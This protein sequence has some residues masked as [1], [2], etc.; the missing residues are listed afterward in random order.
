[1]LT[2]EVYRQTA[3]QKRHDTAQENPSAKG[4]ALRGK[5][6]PAPSVAAAGA[7]KEHA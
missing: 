3:V 4:Y 6:A 5:T 2:A 1:M 7:R